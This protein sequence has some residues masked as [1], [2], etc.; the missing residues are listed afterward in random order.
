LG[1]YKLDGDRWTICLATR[2]NVRPREF[3][4]A[5]GTGFALETLERRGVVDKKTKK[6]SRRT[7]GNS[8]IAIA[9]AATAAPHPLT[10]LEAEWAMVSA[11]FN[12]IRMDESMIKWCKRITRGNV[13]RVVAGPQVFLEATFTLNSAGKAGTIDYSN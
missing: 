9:Q 1:I 11:V 12:G 13:T 4:A 5:P 10:E 3:A 8:A 2:G 7:S 6:K